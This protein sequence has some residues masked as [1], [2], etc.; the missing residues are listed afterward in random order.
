MD[1][2]EIANAFDMSVRKFAETIGYTRQALYFGVSSKRNRTRGKAAIQML[3]MLNH[4]TLLEDQEAAR[5]K[6]E[7]RKAAI[8]EFEKIVLEEGDGK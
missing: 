6:F 5:L 3:E 4:K 2:R 8:K 1:I 7:A